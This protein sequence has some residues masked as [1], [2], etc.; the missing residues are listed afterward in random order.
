MAD[1]IQLENAIFTG[2]L[3]A[4]GGSGT[5]IAQQFKNLTIGALDLD[6]KILYNDTTGALFYDS[7]GSGAT[8]AIQ[9]ATLTA[10]PT[11][12]FNDFFVV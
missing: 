12:T 6:D 4:G 1:T 7:D 8:A 10:S 9:F 5:L 2:I 3:G 11:V